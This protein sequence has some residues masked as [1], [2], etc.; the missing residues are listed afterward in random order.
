MVS[1]Q[2]SSSGVQHAANVHNAE[3]V[4]FF[5]IPPICGKK[6]GSIDDQG[7]LCPTPTQTFDLTPTP[8][9]QAKGN[10]DPF[11]AP[12]CLTM[13]PLGLASQLD[14]PPPVQLPI[15]SPPPLCN[16]CEGKIGRK[17]LRYN[18]LLDRGGGAITP[19]NPLNPF[20]PRP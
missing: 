7:D 5:G 4:T 17:F 8:W 2:S 10:F 18:T 20:G 11:L 12:F 14:P 19:A 1:L 13:A 15:G 9:L 16:L 6:Y 3:G